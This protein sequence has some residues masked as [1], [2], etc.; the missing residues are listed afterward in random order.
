M[1]QDP[2]VEE[3]HRVRENKSN[4]LNNDLHE[5][6]N[7]YRNKQNQ[8]DVNTIKLPPRPPIQKDVA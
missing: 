2:I 5:I 8:S 3:I 7:Y 1:Y 6:C 4:E